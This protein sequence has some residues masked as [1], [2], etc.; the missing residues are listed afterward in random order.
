M[1]Q[2]FNFEAVKNVFYLFKP[3]YFKPKLIVENFAEINF[4]SLKQQ[5]IK[6]L[7]FDKDN[8]ITEPYCDDI[9]SKYTEHWKECLNTFGK[10]NVFILSNNIGTQ[11]ED[12]EFKK[13][14]KLSLVYNVKVLKHIKKKPNLDDL[15]YSEIVQ[16]HEPKEICMIGDRLFTDILLANKY[17]FYSILTKAFSLDKDNKWAKAVS[18]VIFIELCY[19][20]IVVVFLDKIFG[21]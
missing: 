1:V 20:Y 4:H 15:T 11:S 8:C 12:K 16:N 10:D 17:Q 21:I 9:Y 18:F 7:V 14:D 5:G 2:S 6:R 3:S 19:V 13:A